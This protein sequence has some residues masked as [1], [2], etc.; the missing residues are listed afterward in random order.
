MIIIS[1]WKYVFLLS[2][3][4]W[5][6]SRSFK[7]TSS[8]N[9]VWM[10]WILCSYKQNKGCIIS[11]TWITLYNLYYIHLKCC[12]FSIINRKL[13]SASLNLIRAVKLQQSEQLMG[14]FLIC[15]ILNVILQNRKYHNCRVLYCTVQSNNK[16]CANF[17]E[18]FLE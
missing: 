4:K 9:W 1:K 3:K 8:F 2:F 14:I 18:W 12:L 15:F 16:V 17:K 10:L 13:L 5:A 7:T 6:A 11:S